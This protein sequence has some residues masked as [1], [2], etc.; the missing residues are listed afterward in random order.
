MSLRADRIGAVIIC[1]V[2]WAVLLGI[3]L[4]AIEMVS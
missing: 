3:V 4:M 1:G 2:I